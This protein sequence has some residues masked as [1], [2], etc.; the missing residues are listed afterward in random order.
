M[1]LYSVFGYWNL[2]KLDENQSSDCETFT[3][4]ADDIHVVDQGLNITDERKTSTNDSLWK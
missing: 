2:I 4:N 1:Y 3:R